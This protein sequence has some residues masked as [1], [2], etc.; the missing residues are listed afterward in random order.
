MPEISQTGFY[1]KLPCRGDFMQRRAP[2]GFVDGWD[3]W[4]QECLH[5]SRQQ[6][7]E[8]WLDLYLTSPVWRFVLTEGIC[9]ESAYAG[10]MLPSV[11]RVGRY[12]PLTLV[13][14]LQPGS[15]LLEAACGTGRAWFDAVEELAL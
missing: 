8:R 5:A 9:G 14:P 10:V 2:Q 7:G 6:L 1:G 15:C 3:A 4:L 11:D 13:S 12:F